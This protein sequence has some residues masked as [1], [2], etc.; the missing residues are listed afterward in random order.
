[1]VVKIGKRYAPVTKVTEAARIEM[2]K[3]IFATITPQYDFLNRLLSLRR[4]VAWRRFTVG[5]M[6]FFNTYRMLDVGTGTADLAIAAARMHRQAKVTGLDFVWEMIAF[7]RKKMLT[8]D[9]SQRIQV[10]QGDAL[11]LPFPGNA[12][13]VAAIAFTI[14]NIPNKLRA[15]QEMA[16]VVVSGG[17][18]MVLEMTFP[19]SSPLQTIYDLYLNRMLPRLAE[20]FS[21]NPDAYRYLGNSIMNFPDPGGMARLM[22][23]AGL[24]Q[25]RIYPLTLGITCLHV[26]LKPSFAR[27]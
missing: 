13:D 7:G 10:L 15:I 14:R 27:G 19:R 2:V 12:F 5:K 8:T 17:Q 11:A 22:E 3:E 23:K 1:M 25:L 18:V 9:L 21:P 24:G 4:D 26:G 20:A 16:R 6:R